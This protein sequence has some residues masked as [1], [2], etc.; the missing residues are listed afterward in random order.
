VLV[1]RRW[2]TANYMEEPHFLHASF[3][4]LFIEPIAF[5]GFHGK[6]STLRICWGGE[7]V[8][9]LLLVGHGAWIKVC[10]ESSW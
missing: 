5:Q 7:L 6:K 9:F 1:P 3:F 4:N 2:G 8:R 10:E